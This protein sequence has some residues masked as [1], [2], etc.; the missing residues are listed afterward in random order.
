MD[1]FGEPKDWTNSSSDTECRISSKSYVS[2]AN[3]NEG[4]GTLHKEISGSS[5]GMKRVEVILFW[6][7]D[8]DS[9]E[10][11]MMSDDEGIRQPVR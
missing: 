2:F 9:G 3:V 4:G 1:D 8:P 10:I 5:A 11:R 6:I 7:S